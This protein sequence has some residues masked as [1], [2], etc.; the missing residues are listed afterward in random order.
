MAGTRNRPRTPSDTPLAAYVRVS[1][2][3]QAASG[4]GLEAQRATIEA[5]AA[6]MGLRV[7]SW[8][9][10]AGRSGARM[11]NRPGLRA[12]LAEIAAGLASGLIVPKLDRLGRNTIEVL[13]LVERARR[14]GWRLIALDMG[15]AD[16]T[17]P[18]GEMVVT[19]LAMAARFEWR[20]ISERQREKHDAL[21]RAG[22]PRGR[23]AVPAELADR[24]IAMRAE[25]ATYQA[26]ADALNAEGAPTARGGTAWRP[27]TVRSAILSREREQAALAG[28][29]A[30]L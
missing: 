30:S 16:L 15:G 5:A 4:L 6:A 19:A 7:G 26:I 23:P 2:A 25:G 9:E 13:Q 22:R 21:R 3:G 8:H 29:T 20:R 11:G 10:D 18:A 28:H 12:A 17:T 14:E 24:L 1:T 27:S